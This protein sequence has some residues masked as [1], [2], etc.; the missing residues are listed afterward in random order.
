MHKRIYRL[1]YTI[2]K[3]F[4]RLPEIF[5]IME[6]DRTN[7]KNCPTFGERFCTAIAGNGNHLVMSL[8][9]RRSVFKCVSTCFWTPTHALAHPMLPGP[10]VK[11]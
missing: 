7:E 6:N 8:N 10:E 4:Q 9:V 3:K 5:A 2:P 11:I 1:V